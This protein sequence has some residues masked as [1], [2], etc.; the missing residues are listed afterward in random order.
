MSRP[1]CR[2]CM[3]SKLRRLRAGS[4]SV[5]AGRTVYPRR[6]RASSMPR[7]IGG[8]RGLVRSGTRTP[9]A[10]D[11]LVF[12]LRAIGLTGYPSAGG[13]LADPG[14]GLGPDQ[15]AGGLVQRARR[16]GR[17]DARGGRDVAE[18]RARSHARQRNGGGTPSV[19]VGGRL[20]ING[21]FSFGGRS[22]RVTAET[23]GQGD[24]QARGDREQRAV[25][26]GPPASRPPRP[27]RRSLPG[28]GTRRTAVPPAP[29]PWGTPTSPRSAAWSA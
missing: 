9:T 18:C 13:H 4:L 20:G 21:P 17:V 28:T 12:R 24:E 22:R 10:S 7:M 15:A 2:A 26:G 19:R 14:D 25:V 3:A 1:T 6:P 11:R 5:F 8:K 29:A 27:H 23:H 16:R